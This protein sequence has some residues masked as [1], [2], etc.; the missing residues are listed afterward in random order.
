MRQSSDRKWSR[1]FMRAGGAAAAASVLH[2]APML[3]SIAPLR[4]RA[5][6][7]LSGLGHEGHVALTFDDGPDT[8]STPHF[9]E[10]LARHDVRATFFLLGSMLSKAPSLGRD[11]V[12]AGHEVAVHGWDHRNLVGRSPRATHDDLA[13]ARDFIAETTGTW[14]RRF[15]PPYG[16]L[17]TSGLL[18]ARDLGLQPVLW[19]AWGKDWEKRATPESVLRNL[20]KGILRGGTILLHDS[21]CTSAPGAWHSAL[22]ALPRLIAHCTDQ[23]LGIGPLREHESA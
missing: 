20:H 21:D 10:E 9:L 6:P 14:P 4:L 22:G 1:V 19:T 15:R 16:V 2:A 5:F 8:A 11:L 3:T 23:G 7:H 17:T 13:R 12:G 18:A